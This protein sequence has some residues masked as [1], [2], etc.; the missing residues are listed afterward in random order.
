MRRGLA[1]WAL[2]FVLFVV[3]APKAAATTLTWQSGVHLPGVLDVIGPRS[4]GRLVVAATGGL[5]LLDAAGTTTSFAP[6][7]S[8]PP[9]PEPYI[10]ISPGLSDDNGSCVFPRDTVAALDL[11]SNPPGIT[12]ISPTGGLSHLANITGVTGLFGITFDATGQFGH[13]ILVV[14]IG[15]WRADH[16]SRPSIVSVMSALSVSS[17]SRWRAAS[18]SPRRHSASFA[19]QLIAP[20][21]LDGSIYAVSPAGQPQRRLPSPAFRLDRTSA[22]KAWASCRR[23]VLASHTCPIELPPETLIPGM[24]GS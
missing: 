10:A 2:V 6:S 1:L 15:P 9:G 21:E 4:D 12:L 17:T 7:Y 23:A 13:R 11:T 8:P 18:P 16:R 14:G 3:T 19:G 22:S 5:Y 24:T 20:N